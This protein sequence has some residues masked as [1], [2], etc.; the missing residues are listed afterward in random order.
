LHRQLEELL[1][2]EEGVEITPGRP[3]DRHINLFSYAD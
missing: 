1:E 2:S 3:K